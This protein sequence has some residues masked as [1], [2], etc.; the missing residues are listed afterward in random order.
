M[1]YQGGKFYSATPISEIINALCRRQSK[2]FGSD[3]SNDLGF[4]RERE[5]ERVNN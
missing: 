3:F 5:R 2:N 1:Q 4:S